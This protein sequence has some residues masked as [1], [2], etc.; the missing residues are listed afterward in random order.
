MADCEF[1]NAESIGG[2]LRGF[3]NGNRYGMCDA[4]VDRES[5]MVQGPF[6]TGRS[7]PHGALTAAGLKVGRT[8]KRKVFG[9][10]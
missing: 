7:L 2:D 8:V 10:K 1:I 6:E 3:A 5:R 4:E 9:G